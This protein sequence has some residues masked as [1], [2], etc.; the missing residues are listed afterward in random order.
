VQLEHDNLFLVA[1]DDRREWFRYHHLFAQAL[2]EELSRRHNGRLPELH[3]RA[4]P[5]FTARGDV[6]QAI[7]HATAGGD[8]DMAATLVAAHWFEMVNI[9]R[10]A[11]LRGWLDAFGR[12]VVQADG[13]LLMVQA[14]LAGLQGDAEAGLR[15]IS[16]ACRVGYRGE[17]PDGSGTVEESAALLRAS[18]PWSDVGA[19]LS[20][21][22]AAH[23]R[24]GERESV[25]QAVAAMDLG[26]ALIL[27]GAP[28]QARIPLLQAVSV[29]TR[30]EQW[31]SAADA[32]ALLAEICVAEGDLESAQEWVAAAL[33]LAT[34]FGLADLPQVGHYYAV[35]GTIH[36]R[37]GD[38]PEADR[39][40][41]VGL[42]QMRGSWE[43]LHV[44][45][46]LLELAAVRQ[47]LGSPGDGRALIEQARVLIDACP[48]PGMLADRLQ[49]AARTLV[50]GYRRAD[51]GTGLTERELDVLRVLAAGA[52]EREAGATLFVSQS[53]IH[54]HTKSIYFKLGTS[55]RH[56]ALTRARELGLIA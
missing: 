25:W 6:G 2:A 39:L 16:A 3:R 38:Y 32:R 52:S 49:Q 15:G 4:A 44:A 35:A 21:A 33:E 37:G 12:K 14:W 27:A 30:S 41:S 55:S 53:T 34:R 22:R 18:F 47:A 36:A 29:A 13:R 1:L 43:P 46:A 42:Q 19:M 54:S 5:W 56:D 10:L 48:D 7:Q 11:T 31:V 28:E 8:L 45:E 20:A 50:P 23:P 26:W 9:G 40:L 17:H 51:Q 24:E